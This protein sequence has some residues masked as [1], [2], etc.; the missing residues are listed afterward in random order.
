MRQARFLPLLAA[1]ALASAPAP[2]SANKV[3]DFIKKVFKIAAAGEVNIPLPGVYPIP[4]TPIVLKG[5]NLKLTKE[6]AAHV[7]ID[8]TVGGIG[9][10]TATLSI[11]IQGVSLQCVADFKVFTAK[12]EGHLAFDL[13][14]WGISGE[15]GFKVFG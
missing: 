11:S 2:S 7:Q 5:G 13:S 14:D 6:P 10:C 1:V 4:P 12:L 9:I 3:V 15:A 8:L